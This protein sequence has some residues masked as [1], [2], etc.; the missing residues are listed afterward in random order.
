[1]ARGPGRR[2]SIS[3]QVVEEAF[4]V[5]VGW[6]SPS[7]VWRRS[8]VTIVPVQTPSYRPGPATTINEDDHFDAWP[9][10]T[11]LMGDGD[12]GG[13]RR[14]AGRGSGPPARDGPPSEERP[15]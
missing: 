14:A 12:E 5:V 9:G 7:S 15:A 3:A 1:M 8:D 2:C 13:P 6:P 11:T 10:G 4:D